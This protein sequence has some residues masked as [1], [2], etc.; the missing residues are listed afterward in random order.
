M[1]NPICFINPTLPENIPTVVALMNS[2]HGGDPGLL[3]NYKVYSLHT[4][5]GEESRFVLTL[6]VLQ[7]IADPLISSGAP[8]RRLDIFEPSSDDKGS[9][10]RVFP[11]IKSIIPQGDSGIFDESGSY[12]VK[13]TH[14]DQHAV[15]DKPNKPNWFVRVANKEQY[16][17]SQHP[18][19]GIHYSL[20]KTEHCSYLHMNRAPGRTLDFYVDQLSGEEFLSLACTLIEEVPKQIHRIVTVG[21]REGRTIIHCDLKP[22]NIMAQL[23]K[24]ED[25][26]HSEWTVTVIDMGLAKTIKNGEQYSTLQNYGNRMVWDTDMLLARLNGRPR[27]YDIQSDLYAL[28]VSIAELAGAPRRGGKTALEDAENPDF[29]GIFCDMEL[30]P[31]LEEQLTDA[32]RST[33]HPD[34]TQ[35]MKPE[36]ALIIFQSVLNT[37]R[38][39]TAESPFEGPTKK[40]RTEQT[41]TAEDLKKCLEQPLDEIVKRKEQ[42]KEEENRQPRKATLKIWLN[43]FNELRSTA[44]PEEYERFK[45]MLTNIRNFDIKSSFIFDLL[46]FKLFEE[47]NTDACIRLILRHE[48]LTSSLR[49]HFPALSPLP[50]LWQM[51][52]QMLIN[53]IPLQLTQ[54]QAIACTQIGLLKQNITVLLALKSKESDPELA[55]VMRHEL[56]K[57]L[58]LE[59]KVWYQ[60]LPQFARLFNTQ[61]YCLSQVNALTQKLTPHFSWFN[62]LPQQFT[63]WSNDLFNNALQGKFPENYEKYFS[64]YHVM[65]AFLDRCVKDSDTLAFMY[66]VLPT[67]SQSTLGPAGTDSAI[68]QLRLTDLKTVIHLTQQLELVFL[69]HD[70]FCQ[71]MD[72]NKKEYNAIIQTNN[73]KFS[74]LIHQ[75][76]QGSL[77]QE[78]LKT[79]LE[80][81]F[82]SFKAFNKLRLFIDKCSSH[83]NIQKALDILLKNNFRIEEIANIVKDN[84]IEIS[85]VKKLERGLNIVLS[86][87]SGQSLN[88]KLFA[89]ITRYFSMPVRY[90]PPGPKIHSQ[91][92]T[93]Q[94]LFLA[95]PQ[96]DSEE[97]PT[98]GSNYSI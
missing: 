24:N 91:A 33:L 95:S 74:I 29:T 54:S 31:I 38:E 9:F 65:I 77:Q 59:P 68:Q 58:Q 75:F 83:S 44:S 15:S 93:T 56:E 3:E 90:L 14:A 88:E 7:F 6:P 39:N 28:F 26:G 35:R 67:L 78:E 82:D 87:E 27:N 23:N 57:Q 34:K 70:V 72:P 79:Q 94:M 86:E 22:E 11:V 49:K 46:H 81:I 51:R 37:V 16:L 60:Q 63:E 55:K 69:I 97:I 13:Q 42:E 84:Y 18:T 48:Q 50:D 52:F 21:K 47:Y 71:L 61:Y 85:A 41:T 4:E 2:V 64:S 20:I 76:S 5:N 25:D 43:Q 30:D 73:A 89:E 66:N 32:L 92:N 10:G 96:E 45:A 17:G 40:K 19:L 53:T 12:V 36:Q 8:P 80:P 98:P 62:V 1:P